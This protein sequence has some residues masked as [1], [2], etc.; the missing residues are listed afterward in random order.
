VRGAAFSNHLLRCLWQPYCSSSQ[1]KLHVQ[2]PQVKIQRAP[3]LA[4]WRVASSALSESSFWAA[5]P[6]TPGANLTVVP[7][8]ILAVK[9]WSQAWPGW[10]REGTGSSRLPISF[11]GRGRTEEGRPY[12]GM[13]PPCSDP[14]VALLWSDY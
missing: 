14:R 8:A 2:R 13:C 6:P 5:L 3:V 9:Q 4:E 1:V 12:K 10:V 11:Q 7:T